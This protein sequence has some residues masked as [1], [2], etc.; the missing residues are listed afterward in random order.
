MAEIGKISQLK[1]LRKVSYGAYLDGGELG[2]VLLLKKHLP[3]TCETGNIIEV[4]VFI[5]SEDVLQA[6][7]EKPYATIGEFVC[8][9]V[10]ANSSAGSF[11]TWGLQKDLFVPLTEQQDIMEE[12]E[13]YVV[14]VYLDRINQRTIATTKLDKFLDKEEPVFDDYEQVNLL[15]CGKTDL[16]YKVIVNSRFW[17]LVFSNEVFQKIK[18][19]QRLKGYVKLVREDLKLDITLYPS[20]Y[21]KVDQISLEILR[22]ITE[23]GGSSSI[24]DKSAPEEIYAQFEV[25]KKIF[26]KAIG[27]LYKKRLITINRD[28][29]KLV[30]HS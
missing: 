22:R 23:L 8:L 1:V 13:S 2:E 3:E 25:S 18:L 21:E 24:T 12:G 26:K 14:Y 19:G 30:D 16:G 11:L 29:I 4:F 28:F 7:T 27:A 6:T 5:D 10:A 15:V 9:K 17:G 20:G